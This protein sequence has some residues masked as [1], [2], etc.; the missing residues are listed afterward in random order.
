MKKVI[1]LITIILI[2]GSFACLFSC[3]NDIKYTAEEWEKVNKAN[4]T[5]EVETT[6]LETKNT[7]STV[8]QDRADL[9]KLKEEIIKFDEEY[10]KIAEEKKKNDEANS[11]DL[12]KMKKVFSEYVL[13]FKSLNIPEPLDEFYYKKIEQ[14]NNTEMAFISTKLEDVET[15]AKEIKKA[16]LEASKLQR[17]VYREYG[18]DDLINKW[19]E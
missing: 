3:S 9:D 11:G 6:I 14:F 8:Q 2:V 4:D 17:E 7:Q 12:D 19:Q 10:W 18:L 13:K 16:Q 15:L 5:T 1:T